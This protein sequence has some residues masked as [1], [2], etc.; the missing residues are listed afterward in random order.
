MGDIYISNFYK[1][2]KADKTKEDKSEKKKDGIDIII[3]DED[4]K[5]LPLEFYGY[6]YN[7]FI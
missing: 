2:D 4:G 6:I 7:I 3:Q 1:T 5:A